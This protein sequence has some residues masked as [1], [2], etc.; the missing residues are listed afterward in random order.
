MIASGEP[1]H[2]V[3]VA[4]AA[5][6][7]ASSRELAVLR[8]AGVVSLSNHSTTTSGRGHVPIGVSVVRIMVKTRIASRGAPDT[9]AGPP[10]AERGGEGAADPAARATLVDAVTQAIR[11]AVADA[12]QAGVPVDEIA[13][14]ILDAV[15]AGRF[16]VITHESTKAGVAVRARDIIEDRPPTL[17]PFEGKRPPR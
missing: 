3:N 10:R 5:G 16:Y 14:T 13:Q 6:L 4:S 17:F 7:V 1:G 8:R 2:V 12:V 9:G 11:T 15:R